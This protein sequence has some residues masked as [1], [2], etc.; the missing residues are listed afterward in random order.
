MKRDELRDEIYDEMYGV[1]YSTVSRIIEEA[2][3]H[4]LTEKEIRSIVSKH[5]FGE[6]ISY[7]NDHVIEKKDKKDNQHWQLIAKDG[8]TGLQHIPSR[9]LTLLQKRWLK[10]ISLDPRMRLFGE[11]M[12]GLEGIEPLFTEEDYLIFDRYRDG[13]P[14]SEEWYIN[15]FRTILDAIE[16]G[17]YLKI[18]NDQ[19][20]CPQTEQVILPIY[21][22]YSEKDDKFRVIGEGET[23]KRT[24]NLARIVSCEKC[25]KKKGLYSTEPKNRTVEFEVYDKRGALERVLLHFA[26]FR[27]QVEKL[28]KGHYKVTLNY[29][30]D[31]EKE[32]VIRMLSFGPM[33]KVIKPAGFVDLIKSK[34]LEQKSCEH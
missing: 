28:G 7:I 17:E 34:L 6:C 19:A 18:R 14:Y 15:N 32:I 25:E 22:E 21:L 11:M 12:D 10:S 1:C 27:K 16:N 13:D 31:D 33:A 8:S 24:I 4:R 30:K 23:G 9:P 2:L 20:N 3:D 5:A 26:H 29:A